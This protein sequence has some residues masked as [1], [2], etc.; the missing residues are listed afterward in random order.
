MP[1]QVTLGVFLSTGLYCLLVLRIVEHD[2]G[3]AAAPHFSVLLAVMLSVLSLAMLI[4]FIHHVA[5][6]IQAPNVVAAVAGDLEDA[7]TRIFPEELGDAEGDDHRNDDSGREH[8]TRLGKND[9]TVRST[10]DG[11]IQAIDENGLIQLA[12]EHDLLLRLYSR[13]GNFIATG[14]PLADVWTCSKP[15]ADESNADDLTMKLNEAV[16]LGRRRT[17]RQDVECA[18]EELVEIAVRALSPGI[19]DPFTAINCIDRLGA[20]LGRLSERKLPTAYR[21][22]DEGSLRLIVR[23]VSFANAV[24]AAFNQIRQH[25]RDSVAVTIRLL[26]ALASIAEHVQRDEDREAVKLHA[27]MVA[28]HVESFTEDHDKEEVLE[29]LHRVHSLLGDA[30]IALT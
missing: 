21:C 17:P 28:R 29:R 6:L 23:T 19:N 11:Y 9:L 24:D 18:I 30:G 5:M 1:T 16:I 22:D 13:P 4:G 15:S 12:H 2:E 25:G 26:E 8:A 27:E 7:I 14:S 3:G 10:R 20:T